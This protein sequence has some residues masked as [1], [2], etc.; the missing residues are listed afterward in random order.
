MR[1]KMLMLRKVLLWRIL[2]LSFPSV[3]FNYPDHKTEEI[4]WPALQKD[5]DTQ[6]HIIFQICDR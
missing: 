4:Y 2:S 5:T 1:L 3:Y 6:T